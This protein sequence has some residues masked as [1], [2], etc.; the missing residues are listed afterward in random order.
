VGPIE[1]AVRHK[2]DLSFKLL[3]FNQWTI[4]EGNYVTDN[5]VET[6]CKISETAWNRAAIVVYSCALPTQ[7]LA[8]AQGNSNSNSNIEQLAECSRYGQYTGYGHKLLQCFLRLIT[9]LENEV[10]L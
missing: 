3:P 2:K 8:V 9:A 4:N 10:H 5:L 1:T 7:L 6:V